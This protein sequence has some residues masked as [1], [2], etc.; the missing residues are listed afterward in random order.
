MLSKSVGVV[1][2]QYSTNTKTAAAPEEG[3]QVEDTTLE[4]EEEDKVDDTTLEPEE[5]LDEIAKSN[6][7]N[8]VEVPAPYSNNITKRAAQRDRPMLEE[9]VKFIEE[10]PPTTGSVL[11]ES[12]M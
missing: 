11:F 6:F 12:I 4:P 7:T 10:E 2:T 8:V 9:S 5:E 3:D 1:P